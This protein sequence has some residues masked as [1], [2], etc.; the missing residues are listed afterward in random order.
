M[1][2]G[3]EEVLALLE[4]RLHAL[5]DEW[6][7]VVVD[8]APTAETLRLLALPEALGLVHDPGLPGRAPG[9]ARRCKPVLS[10]AAGRAD[11][12]GRRL[13]APSSGCTPSSTRCAPCSPGRDAERAA[14]AD[15]R[16]GGAGRGAAELH[17]A[18]ALRL[19]R[20]RRRG[21]PGLPRRRRRP[22]ARG[23]GGGAGRGARRRS[24][25]S[26]AGHPGLAL[27]VPRRPSRSGSRRSRTSA[28]QVYGGTRPARRTAG[29]GSRCG[30]PGPPTAR[31]S[32]CGCRSSVAATSTSPGTATTWS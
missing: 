18:V 7:A 26:F 6:D 13:R 5:S 16:A 27:G 10:R 2:P 9:G 32:G 21:Q 4:L 31:C 1:I 25:E 28:A 14:G 12:R 15:P 17:D 11:A 3:A 30:S 20:R 24:R 8:C 22:V 19:P 23:L 29:R